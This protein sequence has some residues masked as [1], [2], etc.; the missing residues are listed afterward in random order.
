MAV[1]AAF[2]AIMTAV[3]PVADHLHICIRADLPCLDR[4]LEGERCSICRA[5]GPKRPNGNQTGANSGN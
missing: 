5:D 4:L 2:P 3:M 1:I